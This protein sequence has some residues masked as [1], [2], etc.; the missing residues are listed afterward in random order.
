QYSLAIVYQ[1]LLTG[2]RPFSGTNVR[3]LVL[4]HLHAQPSLVALPAADQPHIARALAKHP[5]DRFPTCKGLVKALRRPTPGSSVDGDG[6]GRV[7]RRPACPEDGS[8]QPCPSDT[9][10]R[11]ESAGRIT[12]MPVP[13]LEV[14]GPTEIESPDL[15]EAGAEEG[16]TRFIRGP[17]P[18]TRDESQT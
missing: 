12:E 3:Q 2:T 6:S 7:P 8:P 18:A 5:D 10:H 11:R 13:L 4:Q 9:P 16:D 15:A 17:S 14:L 1:E